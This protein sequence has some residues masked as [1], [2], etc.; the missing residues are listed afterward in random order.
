MTTPP[1]TEIPTKQKG[2]L[3]AGIILTGIGLIFL[4]ANAHI[5]P[6]MS[7]SWPLIL[8]VVGAALLVG[9]MRDNRQPP[10]SDTTPRVPGVP[11]P[12]PGVPSEP[13]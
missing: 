13:K 5:I 6:R 2:S 7:H 10:S 9:A 12:P 1:H 3:T 8:I 4:L 11:P